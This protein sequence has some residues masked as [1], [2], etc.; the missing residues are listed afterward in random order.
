LK[1]CQA[2]A[3]ERASDMPGEMLYTQ[4]SA[5]RTGRDN[6]TATE[7]GSDCQHCGFCS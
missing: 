6:V 7:I 5:A 1:E 4:R 2:L 3:M